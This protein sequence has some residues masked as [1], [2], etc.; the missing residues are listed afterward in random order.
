MVGVFAM[1]E[2]Q[3]K[4]VGTGNEE[5]ADALFRFSG[6]AECGDYFSVAITSHWVGSPSELRQ[7]PYG[8]AVFSECSYTTIISTKTVVKL[9]CQYDGIVT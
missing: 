7:C 6:W 1:T 5:L 8:P 4:S 2:I 9:H 3:A